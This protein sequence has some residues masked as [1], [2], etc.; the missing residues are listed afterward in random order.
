MK[1]QHCAGK[2]K[3][4][5]AEEEQDAEATRWLVLHKSAPCREA[6]GGRSP[7]YDLELAVR[8]RIKMI[9]SPNVCNGS[10]ADLSR[11]CREW[12]ESRY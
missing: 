7:T 4:E 10:K 9:H 2:A 6:G 3:K 8:H 12:L 1:R 11:Q 5:A